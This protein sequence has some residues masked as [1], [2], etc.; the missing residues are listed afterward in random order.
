MKIVTTAGIA[1]DFVFST[2]PV[3][4]GADV[5]LTA[6]YGLDGVDVAGGPITL[7]EVGTSG[8]YA[9]E[10]TLNSGVYWARITVDG[11]EAQVI[12][13]ESIP[14]DRI[15]AAFVG[16]GHVVASVVPSNPSSVQLAMS[17][18]EGASIGEDS[19]GAAISWPQA[20][21]QVPGYADSWYF[22]SVSFDE[23]A[24]ILVTITPD[25]GSSFNDVIKVTGDT[26]DEPLVNHFNGWIPAGSCEPSAWVHLS[27]IRR[28]TGWTMDLMSDQDLRELR[29]LAVETFLDQTNNWFPAC[30][31]TYHGMRGQGSRLYLPMSILLPSDGGIEPVV[32]Y[33]YPEGEKQSVEIVPQTD[34][35]YRLKG[36]DR[37]QPFI[38]RVNNW[39]DPTLDVSI[40]AT[41]GSVNYDRKLPLKAQQTMVGLIRW[42]SLS[43][44]VDS[45]D[46]RDQATLNR[47]T[48]EQSRDMRVVYDRRAIGDGLTGDRTID[49]ALLE[50]K[51]TPPVWVY[52]CGDAHGGRR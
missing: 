9:T 5:V 50:M 15:T 10:L 8:S 21:V 12:V 43:F 39:W 38:E 4:S 19:L 36:R 1:F 35:V 37:H 45:D 23:P 28:W 24:R 27:Y 30:E 47:I 11:V 44:G 2:S 7:L 29:R 51:I 26:A 32:E 3:N 13:V 16:E 41:F 25:S 14:S 22:D 52:K 34:L 33:V 42:H 18:L 46:A 31:G 49:R 20:M 17:S 6:V 40:T 48:S